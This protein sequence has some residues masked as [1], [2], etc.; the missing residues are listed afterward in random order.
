MVG[1]SA[2]RAPAVLA[3]VPA[4]AFGAIAL[5]AAGAAASPL[6]DPNA[7]RAVFTGATS[8]HPTSLELNP[9]ALSLTTPGW[10]IYLS[11]SLAVDQIGIDREMILTTDASAA[12][13]D[14]PSVSGN[15]GSWGGTAA[16]FAGF[17]NLAVSSLGI[18]I[19]TDPDEV[20]LE[21]EDALR[22]H[23]LGGAYRE[24]K[25]LLG[26]SFRITSDFHVGATVGLVLSSQL[27][28]D[29]AR[30]TALDAGSPCPAAT[31]G[32]ENPM[33]AE[34]YR[35]AVGAPD[36]FTADGLLLAAGLLYQVAP[37]W[38]LG[39]S[40]RSPQ[41]LGNAQVLEGDVEVTRSPASC[42]VTETETCVDRGEATVAFDLPQSVHASLRGRIAPAL[43]L[44]VG[45]RF[46]NLSRVQQYDVR[47][48][49]V[50]LTGIPEWQ[51][52]P[53][54]LDNVYSVVA[55]VEQVDIGQRFLAGGRLGVETAAVPA[56]RISPVQVDGLAITADAGAQLRILPSLVLQVTYGASYYPEV[57]ADPG[58]YDPRDATACAAS[59]YDYELP[60]CAAVRAGYAIP[61]AAGS[62][63][64]FSHAGRLALRYDFL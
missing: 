15:R 49:G 1:S 18:M 2:L 6:S 10:H 46:E 36:W 11:G 40:Y 53:R 12:P 37:D 14:G 44:T 23:T 27:D 20:F 24:L 33:A 32:F 39:F 35:L 61:T 29:Y 25:L 41:G 64:R 50:E 63:R 3:S 28:F 59:G 21:N 22:Y 13:T 55:G 8:G 38:W 56:D 42:T 45:L 62:Y 16:V 17:P 60:A 26:G 48:F 54:S 31:C 51:P 58:A 9:A 57:T 5:A 4:A 47:A 52:R 43:D 34:T 19:A 30:D 7:G